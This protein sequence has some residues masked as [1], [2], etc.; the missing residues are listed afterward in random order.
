MVVVEGLNDARAVQAAGLTC[1]T[2]I[3]KGS[4]DSKAGHYNVPADVI[5]KLAA[6]AEDGGRVVVLTDSDTA[7]R[8]LRSR[9]VEGWGGRWARREGQ[10]CFSFTTSPGSQSQG[11]RDRRYCTILANPVPLD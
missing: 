1:D 7:G 2:V 3:L 5:R 6:T 4:Y 10:L 8:Q 9:Y 11:G